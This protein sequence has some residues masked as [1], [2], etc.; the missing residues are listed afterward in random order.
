MQKC[1]K[2]LVGVWTNITLAHAF[3]SWVSCVEE[4]KAK[5]ALQGQALAF[6]N[7]RELAQVSGSVGHVQCITAIAQR[8]LQLMTAVLWYLLVSLMHNFLSY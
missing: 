1:M 5:R 8:P 6:W 3:N 4:L 7:S 2:T